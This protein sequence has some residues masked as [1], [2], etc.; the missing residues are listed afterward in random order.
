MAV[1]NVLA[2]NEQMLTEIIS[3]VKEQNQ[4]IEENNK[5]SLQIKEIQK[6]IEDEKKALQSATDAKIKESSAAVCAGFDKSIE[7]EKS[8]LRSIQSKRERAK[9]AGV[10]ERI[11]NETAE[12]RD[13]N[14]RRKDHIKEMFRND[15]VPFFC[16]NRCFMLMFRTTGIWQY[17]LYLLILLVVYAVVP[18]AL[19][20]VF[21]V[22]TQII[23]IYELVCILIQCLI[24]KVIYRST[25]WK[26][27]KVLDEAA[28]ILEDMKADNKHMKKIAKRIRKDKSED[29]YGLEGFDNKI[30]QV[31]AGIKDIEEQKKEALLQFEQTVKPNIIAEI[32]AVNQDEREKMYAKLA[33]KKRRSTELEEMIQEKRMYISSNYEAYL[34]KEVFDLD[35]LMK[36]LQIM[37]SGQADTIAKALAVYENRLQ[38]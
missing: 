38:G 24:G 19:L 16:N 32:E 29:M 13:K 18:F 26:H 20:K 34:G 21:S 35:K 9:D 10:K 1:Q 7:E 36:L 31:R 17:I 2:G 25:I 5:V 8:K 22:E 37:K 12:L 6:D 33:E 14:E 3:E 23:I 27:F 30:E 11:A 15:G 28:Q 4:R